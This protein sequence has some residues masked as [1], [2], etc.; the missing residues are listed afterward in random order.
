MI[1]EVKEGLIHHLWQILMNQL[2][3]LKTGL[4]KGMGEKIKNLP[5]PGA[6]GSFL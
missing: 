6:D 1:L 2:I 4:E 5:M 3:I